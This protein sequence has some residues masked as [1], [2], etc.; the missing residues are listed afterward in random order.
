MGAN[1]T[2]LLLALGDV[3]VAW[4]LLWQASV[5]AE[6]VASGAVAEGTPGHDF[7]IGKIAA[8][9]WFAREVLPEVAVARASVETTD[10]LLME[11]PDSAF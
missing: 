8:A 2:R 5:A 9:R 4:L 10:D 3:V 7:R 11:M 1:T 6:Q